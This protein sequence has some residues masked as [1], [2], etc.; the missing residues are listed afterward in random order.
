MLWGEAR[1]SVNFSSRLAYPTDNKYL[2]LLLWDLKNIPFITLRT[3]WDSG[4]IFG[5][6]LNFDAAM[7]GLPAGAMNDYD[8]FFTDREWSHWSLSE[9]T[10][11]WGFS[12]STSVDFRVIDSGPLS[13]HLGLAGL[14]DY[15]YWSDILKELIYSISVNDITYPVPF[16]TSKKHEFRSSTESNSFGKNAVDYEV[17][18]FS[19]LSVFKLKIQNRLR[20]V[21]I[22]ARVG[23]TFVATHD[24]H[25]LRESGLGLR[26]YNW[27]VGLPWV[28]FS[29][30]IGVHITPRV[31]LSFR[32]EIAWMNDI[33]SDTHY[34]YGN[35]QYKNS[36]GAAGNSGFFRG[37][38]SVLLSWKFSSLKNKSSKL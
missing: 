34:Y 23:P 24:F 36:A 5:M 4:K 16:D 9:T 38:M 15:W 25:K 10:L 17:G 13:V 3:R 28:D 14:A 33:V 27:G 20:F 18:Y 22:T 32:G 29:L 6:E 11:R 12:L 7:P 35:F 2:S 1:E 21:E 19:L 37:G 31:S 30:A 8:W 26:I